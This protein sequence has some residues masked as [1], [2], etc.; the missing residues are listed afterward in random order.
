MNAQPRSGPDDRGAV[1][2]EQPPSSSLSPP[3]SLV[4]GGVAVVVLPPSPE[5]EGLQASMTPPS[6]A[7][8]P[9]SPAG[10]VHE[11]PAESPKQGSGAMSADA[12]G[13]KPRVATSKV[14]VFFTPAL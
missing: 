5:G 11:S 3:E 2:H 6:S 14:Q 10:V 9:D 13:T 4:A 8:T 1:T 7:Q 12:R